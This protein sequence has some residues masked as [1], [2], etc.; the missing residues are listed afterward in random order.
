MNRKI[1]GLLIILGG[2]ILS[3]FWYSTSLEGQL[4]R[5]IRKSEP[6]TWAI[7]QIREDL[8]PFAQGVRKEMLD[9]L[10]T[11][12][13]GDLFLVRYAIKNREV[14]MSH[15]ENFSHIAK[16]RAGL[17]LEAL[18]T[19]ARA[20]PLPEVDFVVTVH[21]AFMEK[22]FPG[23]VFAFAKKGH[24][25]QGILFPDAEALGGNAKEME[26]VN[27]G[28][29]KFSWNKKI[30]Q[31]YWRGATTGQNFS[32]HNFLEL[33]RA[34]VVGLSLQ[35]Q[36]LLDAK[37]TQL[38]QCSDPENV[39]AL[40]PN[41]FGKSKHIQKHLAYKYQLLLDGNSCAY[42]RAYW[43]LFSGCPIF[44]HASPHIQWYY[45]A[46]QPN[47]HYIPLKADCSDL[48]DKIEWARTHDGEVQAI[49]QNALSFAEKNLKKSDIL[50]YVHLLLT[51]YAKLMEPS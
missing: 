26:E 2:A 21:D 1:L 24:E 38:A 36:D 45:R 44:K 49:A 39:Q 30:P 8:K 47:V 23:P 50:Y 32:S 20:S 13:K 7:E 42:T 19:L 31:A 46:L 29:K 5:K 34:K 4:A 15:N 3:F 14:S 22:E 17:I 35:Y 6:P 16:S 18:R 11:C 25:S 10:M 27:V 9:A 48:L 33:L 51:E 12:D 40:F 28:K 41:Y 43:Q 37:F